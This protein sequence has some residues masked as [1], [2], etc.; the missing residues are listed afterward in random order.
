MNSTADKNPYPANDPVITE[1]VSDH[2]NPSY[3]SVA[4]ALNDY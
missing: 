1:N 2:V 4:S 3:V